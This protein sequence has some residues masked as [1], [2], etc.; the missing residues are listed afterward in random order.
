MIDGA[1]RVE[2]RDVHVLAATDFTLM[3]RIGRKFI[4]VPALKTLPGTDIARRGEAVSSCRETSPQNSVSVSRSHSWPAHTMEG[5]NMSS[6][7]LTQAHFAVLGVLTL[8][9]GGANATTVSLVLGLSRDEGE[10]LLEDLE[11]LG[12]ICGDP[13]GPSV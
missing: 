7:S 13:T 8:L 5:S 11:R 9:R 4:G 3:C 1:Q 10:R 6:L 12:H 2:F